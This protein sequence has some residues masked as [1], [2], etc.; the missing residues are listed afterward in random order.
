VK[1]KTE[2]DLGDEVYFIERE[3]IKKAPIRR[4]YISIDEEGT[5]I[6]YRYLKTLSVGT[7][8]SIYTTIKNPKKTV[9]ELV[10]PP[11]KS[12]KI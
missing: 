12:H 7:L 4:I 11:T 9:E 8:G 10:S 5:T 1:I 2:F 3:K 6:N